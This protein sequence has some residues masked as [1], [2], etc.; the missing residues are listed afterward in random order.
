MNPN[1]NVP[2]IFKE[3]KFIINLNRIICGSDKKINFLLLDDKKKGL[4]LKK[5]TNLMYTD[6]TG[7]CRNI[8]AQSVL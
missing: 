1:L 6:V 7:V 5:E 2:L 8:C 3:F 4:R